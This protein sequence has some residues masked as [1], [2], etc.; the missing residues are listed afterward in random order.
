[1]DYKAWV[2]R[3]IPGDGPIS[4]WNGYVGISQ[5]GGQG[6]FSDQRI[7]LTITQKPD[8]ITLEAAG[9]ARL[10]AQSPAAR[11]ARRQL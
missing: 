3:P 2:S 4:Y 7:G 1:M 10:S 11:S 8:L 6:N 5:M 9:L